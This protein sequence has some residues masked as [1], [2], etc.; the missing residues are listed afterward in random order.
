MNT[1]AVYSLNGDGTVKVQNS[2]NYFGPNG[3]QSQIT[4][5]A[6]PV[7][8]T[9]NTRLNVGFFFGT[10]NSKEPGNYWIL[11]YDQRTTTG[12]SSVTG[13]DC[14]GYILT[15][16]QIVSETD[17]PE[18]VRRTGWPAPGSSGVWGRDHADQ[19][20]PPSVRCNAVRRFST[21]NTA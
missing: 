10:P 3:P 19:A 11:D 13:A 17:F 21:P 6:V 16:D 4:G 2:G 14:S 8:P 15:R 1:T 12:S 18:R 7:N 9:F 20:V 5:T